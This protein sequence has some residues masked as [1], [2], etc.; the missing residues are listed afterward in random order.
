VVEVNG[1]ISVW[2]AS[3]SHREGVEAAF[4]AAAAAAAAAAVPSSAPPLPPTSEAAPSRV[5]L[6]YDDDAASGSS[7]RLPDLAPAWHIPPIAELA[8]GAGWHYIGYTEN[9]VP[10]HLLEMPENGADVAHLPALHAAFVVPGLSWALSHTWAATWTARSAAGEKHLADIAI[11]EAIALFGWELPGKVEVSILQAGPSQVY[12][13]MQTPVGP[14]LIIETVTP[15]SPL[16]QRTLHA[17]YCPPWFPSV[18]AKAILLA[19]LIQYEK[20]VPVWTSKRY[21]SRPHLSTADKS[22]AAYRRWVM[23]FSNAASISYEEAARA[24]ARDVAGLQ[25]LAW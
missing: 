9:I 21:V 25:A 4:A 1:V 12:L 3:A 18:A 2:M 7:P 23:Q 19:T 17:L 10:A 5:A 14:L 24:H 16:E 6:A 11:S 15:V 13:R 20:D 22:V 8:D